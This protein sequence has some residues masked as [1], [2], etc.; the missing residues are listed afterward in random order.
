MHE[1]TNKNS[2]SCINR[3]KDP[4]SGELLSNDKWTE[5]LNLHFVNAADR[6]VA[7]LPDTE[8]HDQPITQSANKLRFDPLISVNRVS[9][10]LSELYLA[11][12]SGR[13]KISARLYPDALEVLHEQLSYLRNLLISTHTLPSQWKKSIVTSI[14]KKGDRFKMDNIRPISLIHIG[15]KLL[16][17]AVNE[18]LASYLKDNSTL[19]EK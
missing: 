10:I 8:A 12:S 19:S 2:G 7:K 3:V 17:K 15:G 16:E 1:L 14:P 4:I 13:W 5:A 9:N 18:I 11:R 6:L